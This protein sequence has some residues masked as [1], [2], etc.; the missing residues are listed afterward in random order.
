M[1]RLSEADVR[2]VLDV[3]REASLVDGPEPFPEPVL[4]ALR[5]LVPCDVVAYHERWGRGAKRIIWTG[6]PR[7]PTTPEVAMPDGVTSTRIRLTPVGV[8]VSIP[9]RKARNRIDRI[10]EF[11]DGA[12]DFGDGAAEPVDAVTTTVSP[13]RA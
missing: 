1:A 10:T 7:G 5:R 13:A 3:V 4:G 2:Q 8:A 6:N 11:G 12:G 9:S